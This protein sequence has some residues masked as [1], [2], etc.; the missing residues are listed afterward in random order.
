M[1]A[2]M[3]NENKNK[4]IIEKCET[5]PQSATCKSW[6]EVGEH[7]VDKKDM[8]PNFGDCKYC[9]TEKEYELTNMTKISKRM[10]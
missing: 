2:K 9:S 3:K 1:K 10:D 4:D 5:R 6:C 7:F 8:W